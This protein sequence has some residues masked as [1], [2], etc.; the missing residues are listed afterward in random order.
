MTEEKLLACLTELRQ[1]DTGSPAETSTFPHPGGL[2]FSR[3]WELARDPSGMTET[4]RPHLEECRRCAHL[5]QSAQHELHLKAQPV[6]QV[7]ALEVAEP[8]PSGGTILKMPVEAER[9][10]SAAGSLI[11]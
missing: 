3:A 1:R 4:E 9:T 6:E 11:E 8:A 7:A 2:T 10:H 5:L